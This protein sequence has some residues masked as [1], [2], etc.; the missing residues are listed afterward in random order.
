MVA[1]VPRFQRAC[2]TLLAEGSWDVSLVDWLRRERF[3][4]YFVQR[5]IVPQAA[6]VWSADPRQMWSFPARFLAEFFHNH[7]M[8][9]LRQ[10]P[11]WR[12]I[13]GGSARYVEAL[14]RPFA[15]RLRLRTP[16]V[17][18]ARADDH[19]LVTSSGHEPE[20]FDEVVLATHSDQALALLTDSTTPERELLGAIPYAANEAVLHTDTRL[21]PRRRAA[22]ASW[23][24]H[25]LDEPRPAAA[26]TYHMNRLQ[27]LTSQ[28]EF[29]VTLNRT[30]AIDP[31]KVIRTINYAHPIYT[32]AGVR[33][34]KRVDEISGRNRTHFCGA[35][36]GWGFHED[37][38]VSG[39]RVAER[40]GARL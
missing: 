40:F 13:R 7:G 11:H 23:N 8:L 34:Q 30:E 27:S 6:A 1:E 25:L 24:Y 15:D 20:R 37:G 26:V 4:E 18:V 14:T 38:V 32:P 12:V 21:L 17:A 29:C 35:Y 22:W 36:W 2:R 16:V 19:V 10:R 3:S 5:L 33:A 9:A 39:L 31:S 28:S